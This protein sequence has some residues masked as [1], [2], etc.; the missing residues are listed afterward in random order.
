MIPW[1][2]MFEYEMHYVEQERKHK[3]IHTV[4][5]NFCEVAQQAKLIIVPKI[6][7]VMAWLGEVELI[8]RG[9]RVNFLGDGDA[10]YF[11]LGG[12]YV[13]LGSYIY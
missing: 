3:R 11:L 1:N 2:N 10:L 8:E 4:W 13:G 6:R 7:S 5:F 12:I 9:Q